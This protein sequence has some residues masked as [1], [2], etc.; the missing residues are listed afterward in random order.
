MKNTINP[1]DRLTAAANAVFDQALENP[2]LG[3]PADPD[4]ADFMGCFE[5]L[6]VSPDDFINIDDEEDVSNDD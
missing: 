5:E 3:I 6:A 1:T 4:V 2:D